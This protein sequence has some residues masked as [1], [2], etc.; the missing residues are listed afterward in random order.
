MGAF[1]NLCQALGMGQ[2]HYAEIDKVQEGPGASVQSQCL[3]GVAHGLIFRRDL[4]EDRPRA[5]CTSQI[6]RPPCWRD[7]SECSGHPWNLLL[8][9]VLSR[10]TD[11]LGQF[12]SH[13]HVLDLWP[14][15]GEGGSVPAMTSQAGAG[16][17]VS[18]TVLCCLVSQ[19]GTGGWLDLRF[20][21]SCDLSGAFHTISLTLVSL[22]LYVG[23]A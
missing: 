20:F 21:C 11:K 16:L 4:E 3:M 15:L 17:L 18:L 5:L 6:H 23:P 8:E 10:S 12:W 22:S 9:A 2:H 19:Q 1:L 14:F 13:P 7:A